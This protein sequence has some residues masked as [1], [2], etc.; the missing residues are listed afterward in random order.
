MISRKAIDVGIKQSR[1][2]LTLKFLIVINESYQLCLLRKKFL[3]KNSCME[4]CFLP[5]Q[6][7]CFLVFLRSP[8]VKVVRWSRHRFSVS[9]SLFSPGG[10]ASSVFS[11]LGGLF[12]LVNSLVPLL[13]SNFVFSQ[14][15]FKRKLVSPCCLRNLGDLSY[16]A[17]QS[18]VSCSL[19]GQE[20]QVFVC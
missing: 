18:P 13:N 3:H 7:R 20:I 5:C 6:R 11:V 4:F 10:L 17:F 8:I 19:F 2:F 16:G 9:S 15:G 14:I 1:A 12:V